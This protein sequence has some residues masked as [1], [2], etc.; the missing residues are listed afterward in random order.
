MLSQARSLFLFDAVESLLATALETEVIR[1][2]PSPSWP[3]AKSGWRPFQPSGS[4]PFVHASGPD[5][6]SKISPPNYWLSMPSYWCWRANNGASQLGVLF[7]RL[8]SPRSMPKPQPRPEPEIPPARPV[9]A[10]NPPRFL[11]L[12][13]EPMHHQ[14]TRPVSWLARYG[15]L[16]APVSRYR[17]SPCHATTS[18]SVRPA[19]QE[20]G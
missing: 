5:D 3:L 10:N 1:S 12:E 20:L 15:C 17:C 9:L 4:M 16:H 19:R 14:D 8:R 11:L 6:S 7:R 13:R 2:A 18:V